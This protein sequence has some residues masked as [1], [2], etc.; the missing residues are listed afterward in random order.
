MA[1]LR[2]VVQVTLLGLGC[3]AAL[4]AVRHGTEQRIDLNQT[5]ALRAELVALTNDAS[6][7]PRDLPDLELAPALWRL[8]DGT[9]LVRS[10]AAG[11][12]GPVSLLYTVLEDPARLGQLRVTSHQETPGITDFLREP[13]G[14]LATL[15]GRTATGLEAL[16]TVSGATITSRSLRDHLAGMLASERLATALTVEGCD[17]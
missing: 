10:A 17:A 7:L 13:R 3:A 2:G 6:A 5:R 4:V 9:L 15:A 16:S 11:Y 14:W 8:C 12:G 1:E